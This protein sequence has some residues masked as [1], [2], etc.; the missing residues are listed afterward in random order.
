MV[1]NQISDIWSTRIRAL[2]LIAGV[3]LWG[4]LAFAQEPLVPAASAS[5]AAPT[6][7]ASSSES[8][9]VPVAAPASASASASAS[10]SAAA[11]RDVVA[12]RYVTQCSG[13][14]TIGGGKLKGPDLE[15]ALDWSE[16]SL[17][18]A[19]K[20]MEKNV[21]AL[22][23]ADVAAYVAFL[24]APDVRDRISKERK[25]QLAEMAAKLEPA[26][27]STGRALFFGKRSFENQGLACVACHEA[28][29]EG[30]SLGPDL[31]PLASKMDAV[32]MIS[33]FEQTNFAV[34]R[35]A[36]REH[37]ITKQEAVHLAAF[38]GTVQ[39]SG[40]PWSHTANLVLAIGATAIPALGMLSLLAL[41]RGRTT[42]VRARLVRSALKR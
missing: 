31:T 9:S 33:A 13:C 39:P 8:A 4:S 36:Y 29:G 3:V 12:A 14:H 40:A 34:M 18:L 42:S 5:G 20:K 19:V 21:G 15:K 30:G 41:R 7:A 24:K 16:G 38:L 27:A 17:K 23:D 2:A 22:P 26:N 35:D 37:A 6:P 10:S 11:P 32:G 28:G 25:R 1:I